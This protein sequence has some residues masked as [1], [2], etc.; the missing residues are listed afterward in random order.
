MSPTEAAPAGVTMRRAVPSWLLEAEPALCPCGC[1]GVRRKR[2]FLEQTLNASAT[3]IRQ[4]LAADDAGTQPG[5]VHR[6]DPLA[7]VAVSLL[8]HLPVAGAAVALALAVALV[9]GLPWREVLGRVWLVVP[10]FTA[11]AVLPATL[12]IVTAGTVV[13]QLWTWHGHAQGFTIQ[14]LTSAGLIIA[15]TPASVTLVLILTRTTSWTRLL[16][17]LRSLGVPRIIVMI[18]A[19]AYRYLILLLDTI[20]DMFQAR[21]ARTLGAVRRPNSGRELA[22]HRPQHRVRPGEVQ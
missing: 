12:S 3:T 7:L 8:H 13:V 4:I 9:A 5:L 15:R 18:I 22:A 19:M 10:L 2:S 20:T 16:T 11:I 21:T 14:G 6:L 1:I 17:G